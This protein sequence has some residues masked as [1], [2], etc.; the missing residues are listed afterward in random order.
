MS[1]KKSFEIKSKKLTEK[2]ERI[3]E[4]IMSKKMKITFLSGPAGTGKTYLA[5]LAALKYLENKAVSDI[6]YIRSVVE[7]ADKSLGFLPGSILSKLSPFFVPFLDK[8]EELI[9]KESLQILKSINSFSITCPNLLRGGQFTR[10]FVIIDEAQNL[11]E[12]EIITILTRIG[13]NCKVLVLGDPL[14]SDIR[15]SCFDR[16]INAFSDDDSIERGI[17]AFHFDESDI[18]RSELLSFIIPRLQKFKKGGC[19]E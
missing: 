12:K 7:S 14:Q 8:V 6:L 4:A 2:Q 5:I 16:L 1:K 17:F 13:E 19:K 9:G 3:L 15:S 10:K 11:T 18:V